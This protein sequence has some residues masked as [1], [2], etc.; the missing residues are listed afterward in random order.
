MPY[1]VTTPDGTKFVTNQ[2]DF[3]IIVD[4]AKRCETT[5]AHVTELPVAGDGSVML[6]L[7][8]KCCELAGIDVP[9]G[10]TAA[11][12]EQAFDPAP[13]DLPQSYA[14]GVPVP[15]KGDAPETTQADEQATT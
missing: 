4:V 13:D 15:T 9:A 6:A 2:L 10:L 8:E 3:G 7:F 5:W 1:T 11:D 12:M 14:D